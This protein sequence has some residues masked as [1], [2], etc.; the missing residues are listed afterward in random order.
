MRKRLISRRSLRG[1]SA[2][3]QRG[4]LIAYP[5]ES[6]Y[7]LGGLPQNAQT[8]RRLIALK[9]RPQHKGLIVIGQDLTQLQ[10][11]LK[12]LSKPIQQ[13]LQNTWPACKTFVLPTHQQ[14]LP[15]LRGKGRNAL[16]VRVPDHLI[17][18][19]ICHIAQTPLI[20]TSCNRAGRK[21][22]RNE[23]EVRRQ[24][25]RNVWII[26]GKVGNRKSPSEII[27]LHGNRIR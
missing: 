16:A 1:L 7:G 11:L 10:P 2:H 14:I 8:L 15:L 21:P 12:P 5:T 25:G 20:S 26:G 17:A 19:Q 18:R 24:F 27:D 13:T 22:C 4:G 3:L 6:C 23:R 9:K